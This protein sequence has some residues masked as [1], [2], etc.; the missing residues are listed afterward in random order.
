MMCG[1]SE[2]NLEFVI[3]Y[4]ELS[5][6]MEDFYELHCLGRQTNATYTTIIGNGSGL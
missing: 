1:R 4:L 2:I 3:H 5:L 6:F